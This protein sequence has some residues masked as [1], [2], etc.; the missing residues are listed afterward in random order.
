MPVD[1][2]LFIFSW[3]ERDVCPER[4][5]VYTITTFVFNVDMM[6]ATRQR[7]RKLQTI[8]P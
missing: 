8:Q 5:R 7:H 3:V 6:F 1:F 4:A 2:R